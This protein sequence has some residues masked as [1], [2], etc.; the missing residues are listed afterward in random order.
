MALD[1]GNIRPVIRLARQQ[2]E[3]S[4]RALALA[5]ICAI[6][7]A[8]CIAAPAEQDADTVSKFEPVGDRWEDRWQ[9][10]KHILYDEVLQEGTDGAAEIRQDCRAVAVRYKRSDG[11]TAVRRESR[12][13]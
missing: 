5:A 7:T 3:I 2:W 13:E 10:R 1:E 12:C 6:L 11:G 9:G 4:M 8:P